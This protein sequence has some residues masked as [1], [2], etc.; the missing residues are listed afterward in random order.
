MATVKENAEEYI[1]KLYDATQDKQ[2]QMLTDAYKVNTEALDTEK[3]NVQNQTNQYLERTNV[4]AQ[5]VDQQYKPENVSSAV[6]QQAALTM[7]NQQKKNTQMLQ[8][9][10]QNA[11]A[12]YERM[13][14]LYADQFA[15]EIKKAQAEN[16][17]ARAEQLYEAAKAKEHELQTFVYGMGE[18]DNQALIDQIYN[19]ATEAVTQEINAQKAEKLSEL[20]AQ[21]QAKQQQTDEALTQTYVDAL[22]KNQN[23][24]EYQNARGMGS[25]NVAQ[26]RLARDMGTTEA[27]TEL[28]KAQLAADA[29][30]GAQ[31]VEAGKTAAESVADVAAENER[32][33][34]QAMYAEALTQQPKANASAGGSGGTG[35]YRGGGTG[36]TSSGYNS[37]VAKRQQE[38]KDMGYN[39]AVD[40]ID[41]PQTQAANAQQLQNYRDVEKDI[42]AAK[43]NGYY[44]QAIQSMINSAQKEGY[45]TQ[46]Q[47][48]ELEKYRPGI[49]TS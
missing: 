19:N 48:K 13:R 23:M 16:D 47:K 38:L 49:V 4:E 11:N 12:E 34:A 14:K 17:K 32:K 8:N 15:A 40:G 33:R 22:R 10:Q 29:N 20:A 9:Q 7:E 3:Q 35:A 42:L 37:E 46:S 28:R 39:I 36:A 45:I 24:A 31:R 5:R 18:L 21:Q 2:K 1:N 44:G 27:L 30:L 25:G 43:A 41:G 26:A 6:N